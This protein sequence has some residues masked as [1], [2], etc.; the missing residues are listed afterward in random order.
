MY[1]QLVRI[2]L[3][4]SYIWEASETCSSVDVH[5]DFTLRA[6]DPLERAWTHRCYDPLL[7]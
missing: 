5:E 1:K 7:G 4:F 6:I 3:V 2:K